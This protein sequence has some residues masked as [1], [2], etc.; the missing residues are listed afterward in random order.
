MLMNLSFLCLSL[1]SV[2]YKGVVL[3]YVFESGC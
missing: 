1:G 3:K 2:F